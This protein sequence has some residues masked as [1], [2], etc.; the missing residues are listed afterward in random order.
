MWAPNGNVK[1]GGSKK[2]S[3]EST[4]LPRDLLDRDVA[5][6]RPGDREAT[7]LELY[8]S[9]RGFQH[10]RRYLPGL[11]DDP[12]SGHVHCHTAYG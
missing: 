4:G 12:G 3:S 6:G 9:L 1:F 10:V 8:V 5:V 7:A 11:V 2:Y